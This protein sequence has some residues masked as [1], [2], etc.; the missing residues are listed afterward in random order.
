MST[1]RTPPAADSDVPEPAATPWLS[2]RVRDVLAVLDGHGD[3]VALQ[4]VADDG[5]SLVFTVWTD[6]SLRVVRRPD[7]EVP[8]FLWPAADHSQVRV[9]LGHAG[10]GT[11]IATVALARDAHGTPVR[12]EIPLGG[13]LLTVASFGGEFALSV[14]PDASARAAGGGPAE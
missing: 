9:G 6:W 13:R 8:G 4:L 1:S 10:G 14:A 2:V 12:A 7:A 11:R 3:P 5:S